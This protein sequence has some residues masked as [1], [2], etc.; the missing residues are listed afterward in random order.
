[1]SNVRCRATNFVRARWPHSHQ[2]LAVAEVSPEG[3]EVPQVPEY[4]LPLFR[5]TPSHV[6]VYSEPLEHVVTVPSV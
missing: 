1:M 3:L 4:E 6:N 5:Q 2:H